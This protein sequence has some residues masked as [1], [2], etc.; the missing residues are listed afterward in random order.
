MEMVFDEYPHK[1]YASV[2]LFDNKIVMWKV[3][4]GYWSQPGVVSV[5]SKLPGHILEGET[6][7]TSFTVT[8]DYEHERVF[9][10]DSKLWFKNWDIHEEHA[11]VKP[12]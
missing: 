9:N 1:I 11:G 2:L 8:N 3:G 10:F 6:D 4:P 5:K 12:Y 7:Y